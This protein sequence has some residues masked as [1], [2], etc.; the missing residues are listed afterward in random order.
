MQEEQKRGMR[1]MNRFARNIERGTIT[2]VFIP[3]GYQK[4]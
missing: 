3:Y 4:F 1:D 2:E